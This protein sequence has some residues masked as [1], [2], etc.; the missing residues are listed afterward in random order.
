MKASEIDVVLVY[1]PIMLEQKPTD[2]PYG[3]MY[4]ASVLR[5]AGINVSI[6]DINAF[7]YSK[8]EVIGFF[9]KK[10][11]DVIGIGGMT[12]VYYYIKWL[13]LELKHLYPDIPIIAGGSAVTPTPELLLEHTGI[14]VACLGE[15]EPII[16]DLVTKLA[17]KGQLNDIP[18]IVY[19]EKSQIARTKPKPRIKELDSLPY[20]AYDLVPMREV[21][22]NNS[23]LRPSLV[24]FAKRKNI[25]LSNMSRP[26]ILFTER[27]CPYQCAFCYRNFGGEFHQHSVDYVLNH[28]KYVQQEFGV[29]NI[30][31][32]DENFNIN[33][34]WVQHFCQKVIEEKLDCYF[35]AGGNRAD[36][37]DKETLELMQEANF[38]E[39]SVGVESFEQ[40]VLNEMQKKLDRDK[41]YETIQLIQSMGMGPSY[42]GLLFG[43]KG[44]RLETLNTSLFYIRKLNIPAYFAIP[45]PYPGTQ[46]YEDLRKEGKINDEEQY[47]LSLADLSPIKQVSINNTIFSDE[48]LLYLLRNAEKD[49]DVYLSWA[50]GKYL[51]SIL[52]WIS[53]KRYQ[54]RHWHEILSIRKKER[55]NNP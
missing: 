15:S 35:W 17:R 47:M 38:Y 29:N 32:Y 2:P 10:R 13:S 51:Y 34:K 19:K 4:L 24:S 14:D 36:L 48:E 9:R 5:H 22:L 31:F 33:K 30:A 12:T 49:L 50:K 18:G 25:P 41:M 3:E 37:F 6:L 11:F 43:F 40:I 46:L 7:R 52:N 21:Y 26:F 20:P 23:G 44:D 16:V 28:I 55:M 1:P 8:Q 27:G 42:L 45:C 54:L 39:I 53:W